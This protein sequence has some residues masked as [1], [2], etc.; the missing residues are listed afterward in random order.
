[1]H[2]LAYTFKAHERMVRAARVYQQDALEG[3]TAQESIGR[4]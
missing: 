1:M 2:T 4:P 3:T